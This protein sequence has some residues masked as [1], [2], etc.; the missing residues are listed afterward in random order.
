MIYQVA[1]D[2][3]LVAHLAFILFAVLGSLLVVRHPSLLLIHLPAMAWA[4]WIEFN[5]GPCPLTPL[6]NWLRHQAG[7][8]GYTGG[9]I[10]H[11]VELLIYP[12]GLTRKVQVLL[13]TAVLIINCCLYA[14]VALRYRRYRRLMSPGKKSDGDEK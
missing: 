1:A 4:A 2:I 7:T 12:P 11:Y 10:E 8:K 13:G 14:L 6:E 9:F 5:G 3:V